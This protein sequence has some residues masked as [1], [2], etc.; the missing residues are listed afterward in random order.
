MYVF[1]TVYSTPLH[2]LLL[3]SWRGHPR[4]MCPLGAVCII[5]FNI[6]L[7]TYPQPGPTRPDPE[8]LD[9]TRPL[10]HALA[11]QNH[12]AIIES[13]K[14]FTSTCWTTRTRSLNQT[15]FTTWKPNFVFKQTLTYTGNP[16]FISCDTSSSRLK[17]ITSILGVTHTVRINFICA[18]LVLT[19]TRCQASW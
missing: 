7:L 1:A 11:H 3:L 16:I 15:P 8:Q 4:H 12:Y 14:F 2:G 6:Y 9:S 10:S 17:F 5:H 18:I 13:V 19:S